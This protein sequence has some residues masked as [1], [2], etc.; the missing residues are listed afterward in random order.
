[1]DFVKETRNA[2]TAMLFIVLVAAL[3]FGLSMQNGFVWDD[4]ELLVGNEVYRSFDLGAMLSGGA[5][6]LEYLPVRDLSFA[7]DAQLW[8]DH[9][10]GYH[11]TN[12]LL[13]LA[14]LAALFMMMRRL[15]ALIGHPEGTAVA[16]WTTLVFALHPIHAEVV[17]WITGRNTLLAGLFLFLSF[18]ELARGIQQRSAVAMAGSVGLFLLAV[19]SKAIALFAPAFLVALILL[20]PEERVPRRWTIAVTVGF[21]FVAVVTAWFHVH[22]ASL[23]GVLNEDLRFGT[24]SS[25]LALAKA[26]QIPW[27][28]LRMLIVPYPLTV[29]Y[30]VSFL[31]GAIAAR[32]VSALLAVG[33]A[34]YFSWTVRKRAPLITLGAAW[35]LF[36][37]V[38]VM[39]L[40]PTEPVVA[41][42]YAFFPIAGIGMVV[43]HFMPGRER[44]LGLIAAGLCILWAG[45]SV[46]RTLDW[47]SDETLWRSA[48]AANPHA[49]RVNLGQA[50][51]REG[52]YEEALAEFRE[53]RERRGSHYASFYEGMLFLQRR[54]FGDAIALLRRSVAEGGDAD[55]EVL[56]T[57]GAAYEG[58]GEH[59]LA[60][61]QY[62]RAVNAR[63]VDVNR[64]YERMARDGIERLRVRF[65][66][67]LEEL[68]RLA[69]EL[70]QGDARVL[71]N[72]GL[73]HHALG[74]YRDAEQEYHRSLEIDPGHWEVWYNLGLVQMR[75]DHNDKAVRSFDRAL[76]L[77]EDAPILN[78]Q[79]VA[80][81]RMR[82]FTGAES[83]YQRALVINPQFFYAAFN[84]ARVAFVT[85]DAEQARER[86]VRA[87]ALASNDAA[88]L[89]RIDRYL[90]AIG[91]R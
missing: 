2:R 5:N 1:M 29:N 57:L 59:R 43:A 90:H 8:G 77:H 18:S 34:V 28:Y 76:A 33:A 71:A 9:P 6:A 11:F 52:R 70:G 22:N 73:E 20:L 25:L 7:L 75:L 19:L 87:R 72:L 78:N 45:V 27:F 14:G 88:L 4:W 55:R 50:L 49:S 30:A 74:M 65:S 46:S 67:R 69:N 62:L 17:N 12:L 3:V 10:F 13:Y 85:G 16:F 80:F 31:D 24:G 39:N 82:D 38:P 84:L 36:S 79:G 21:F 47:R 61:D 86:F 23:S 42:R 15:S 91:S 26:V 41:D 64:K 35:F 81:M 54:S 44:R 89:N 32:A 51:W 53:D 48:L 37:L 58:A 83:A 56:V 40:F 66:S 68:Q 60:L 63:S